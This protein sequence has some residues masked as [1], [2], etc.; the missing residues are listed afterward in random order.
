MKNELKRLETELKNRKFIDDVDLAGLNTTTSKSLIH[1]EDKTK[2]F[3]KIDDGCNRYADKK[4]VF[5]VSPQNPNKNLKDKITN[6]II[7]IGKNSAFAYKNI[8]S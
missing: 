7:E 5:G 8:D 4:I 1:S 3:I 6:I 2:V